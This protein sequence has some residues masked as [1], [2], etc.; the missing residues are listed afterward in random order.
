MPSPGQFD[1]VISMVPRGN[2]AVWLDTTPEVAPFAYL[3]TPLRG[4]HALVIPEDKAPTLTMT[5]V[6]PPTKASQTF[7]ID[8]KLNDSGT[9]EGKIERTIQGDDLEVML[10][11][12]FRRVPMP[13]WKDLI[14]QISYGSG[15]AGDVSEVTASSPEKTDEPFRFSYNYSRKDFP[16][17]SN[18]RNQFS[19]SANVESSPRHQAFSSH[20]FWE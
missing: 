16:D 8:A 10:R 7:K 3:I 11:S 15:F 17:W 20:V 14:Q 19:A 2:S 9:L 6:D 4:K 12:A 13:Q 5:P 1:H 18:R